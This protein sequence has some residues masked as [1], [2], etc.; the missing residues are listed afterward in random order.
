MRF[1][2]SRLFIAE[3][4]DALG[5]YKMKLYIKTFVGIVYHRIRMT[6]KTVHVAVSIRRPPIRHQYQNLMQTFRI[7]RPE[8]PHHSG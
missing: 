1:H 2:L 8:I 4:L 5:S 6:A 7:Q 3:I